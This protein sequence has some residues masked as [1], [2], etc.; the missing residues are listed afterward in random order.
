MNANTSP[1]IL[2]FSA[3]SP[4][5]NEIHELIKKKKNPK[6]KALHQM[7][8]CLMITVNLLRSKVLEDNLYFEFL[9]I[10]V[11]AVTAELTTYTAQ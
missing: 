7:K 3:L 1:H 6:Q 5:P 2:F 9:S 8:N 11:L 10:F 4:A